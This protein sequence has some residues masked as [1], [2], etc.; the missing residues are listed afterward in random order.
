[1]DLGLVGM[2]QVGSEEVRISRWTLR[3]KLSGTTGGTSES[4]IVSDSGRVSMSQVYGRSRFQ[5]IH[6]SLT[7]T[8]VKLVS[9]AFI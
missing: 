1:M 9:E 6:L 8:L 2:T 4:K 7:P 3:Q 5:F